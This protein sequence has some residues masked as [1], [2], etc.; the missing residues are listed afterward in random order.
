M[1]N[2]HPGYH[3][4]IHDP[5]NWYDYG[6]I[7]HS[8]CQ[9]CKD[10]PDTVRAVFTEE[11]FRLYAGKA[12]KNNNQNNNQNNII[13]IIGCLTVINLLYHIKSWI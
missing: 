6:R 9:K 1:D 7:F 2:I 8:Q 5:P 4:D 13:K 10:L 3:F 12:S 11:G